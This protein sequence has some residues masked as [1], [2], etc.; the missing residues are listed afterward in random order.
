MMNRFRQFSRP[1]G[2]KERALRRPCID[3]LESK[4]AARAYW[5]R[6][7]MA[8]VTISRG[9]LQRTR[10]RSRPARRSAAWRLAGRALLALRV[11]PLAIRI[12]L[13][14]VLVVAVW[15]AVN[16]MVQVARK[17]AEV[18]FPVSGS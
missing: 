7:H 4:L 14:T 8:Y 5:S 11:A 1:P 17:P 10:T 2:D 13:G 12:A 3:E 18:F 6:T 16:W 9:A 15:A